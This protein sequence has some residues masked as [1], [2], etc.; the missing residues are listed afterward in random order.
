M[1]LGIPSPDVLVSLAASVAQGAALVAVIAGRVL[2][3]RR[4]S[5]SDD[6]P[7]AG[8]GG[9][10]LAAWGFGI[11]FAATAVGFVVYH[12]SVV[13]ARQRRLSTNLYRS[14]TEAGV[15]VGDTSLK[16]LGFSAQNAHPRG[17][18][19][20]DLAARLASGTPPPLFDVREPEE[21]EAGVI[22]GSVHHRY[23]DLLRDR[24]VLT[25]AA[26][27]PVLVCYS[28]N[29]SSELADTFAEQGIEC[30]FL[31]GG[32]EKWLAEGRPLVGGV[33]RSSLRALPEFPNRD[34]LLDTPE[35]QELAE[36]GDL[37]LVD[38]RYP[39]DLR[40]HALPGVHNITLRRLTTPEVETALRGLPEGPV[41]AVCYDKRG[42]FYGQILGLRMHRMGRDFRG[43]YTVPHEYWRPVAARAHVAAWQEAQRARSLLDLV[44][45]PLAAALT[46][47][48]DW[49]PA[50]SLVGAIALLV[51]ALRLVMLPLT[52]K[53]DVDQ[54]VRED[55][56]PRL[57]ALRARLA[58]EPARRTRAL[59]A[60]QRDAGLTPLRN[61]LGT[62]AIV[63]LFLVMF[64]VVDA[65]AAARPDGFAW[66]ADLR[67]PDPWLAVVVGGLS[68]AVLAVKMRFR[69]P[70]IGVLVGAAFCALLVWICLQCSAAVSI[71]LIIN[72]A[73]VLLLEGA[74]RWWWRRRHPPR[75]AV[76]AAVE[77]PAN[78]LLPLRDAAALGAAGGKARRLG[79]LVQLGLPVPDGFVLLDDAAGADEV[80]AAFDR[81][82]CDEVAVRSSGVDEDGAEHSFAGVFDTELHV[83]RAQLLAAVERVRGSAMS[84]RATAYA[85]QQTAA[86]P[87]LVQAMVPAER[88]G[89]LFT[90][91]PTCTGL[92][93]VEMIDGVGEDLVS[94]RRTPK[95]LRFGRL[96]GRCLDGA[97][98]MDLGPLLA[99]GA[100]LERHFGGPQDVEWAWVGGEYR[101]LQA[102]DITV[103]ATG[104]DSPAAR[105][106]G[107][108]RR[109]MD[110]WLDDRR[111]PDAALLEQDELAE[112]LPRPTAYSAELM[113]ALWAVD[114]SVDRA[115]RALGVPYEVREDSPS[116]TVTAFGRTFV[117][118]AERERRRGAGLPAR[119][120]FR[121]TLRLERL[122]RSAR[123][124]LGRFEQAAVRRA[125]IDAGRLPLAELL[126]MLSETRARFVAES[127]ARAE[128]I[129]ILADAAVRQA[130]TRLGRAGLDAAEHLGAPVEHTVVHRA[131]QRL[132]D[133]DC[134]VE[135]AVAGFLAEFA[136]RAPHDFELSAPRYG[137]Q[138]E[139]MARYVERLRRVK[140]DAGAPVDVP[141]D[142]PADAGGGSAGTSD[143]ERVRLPRTAALCVERAQRWQELKEAAK[144]AC[145]REVSLLRSLL[146]ELGERTGLQEAVF[147]LRSDELA[148][149][150]DPAAVADLLREAQ[151]RAAARREWAALE[152]PPVIT[153]AELEVVGSPLAAAAPSAERDGALAGAR[154]AGSGD[155]VGTVRCMAEGDPH[156]ALRPGEIL[157]TRCTDPEWSPLFAV[158]GGIVTEIG[159]WLSHAAILARECGLPAIVGAV[160]A[161]QRLRTG[162]VVR[163]G[164]DGGIEVLQ[165]RRAAPR[166]AV[167]EKVWLRWAGGAR[168]GARLLNASRAGLRVR[169][170]KGA[171]PLGAEVV[172][173]WGAADGLR[174][175]VASNGVCD[176]AGL[177]I[178]P[179]AALERQLDRSRRLAEARRRGG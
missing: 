148:R 175:Q 130:R 153:A 136:H 120:A 62:L 60:A 134:S 144:H 79:E 10:R 156:D 173:D 151:Q 81:L 85:G 95:T 18:D 29:R 74:V 20:Q 168:V 4:E 5:A 13:D 34:T 158:A 39:E 56:A 117:D 44:R 53:A 48:R 140:E 155:V 157:V 77:L 15:A 93:C 41:V 61:F 146:L 121:L 142:V 55:L 12:S 127:Y 105:L 141:A 150:D 172:V 86:I 80:L 92:A 147:D 123:G 162:D 159:G 37:V 104:A 90:E 96:S 114:G 75:P 138:P 83:G 163:L 111:E 28:G 21:T 11:A 40:A 89:V 167:D 8:K 43:R 103:R 25:A 50:A 160:G 179:C 78:G 161:S 84:A 6:D 101:L 19:S 119:T 107:E 42:S 54:R 98:P 166:V 137:E 109:L 169:V 82:G 3:G 171:P 32:Y 52:W 76:R 36:A 16:T 59:L 33:E 69:R 58:D 164:I 125:A 9:A 110:R 99:L 73:L 176:E 143:A 14:S 23:P 87:V 65:E 88:A 112:L 63:V 70:W 38:V 177:A 122:E 46:W 49:L 129:N 64:G 165:E 108:R 131:W 94:G 118:V 128:Q 71:Y 45:E 126:S 22:A 1:M 31:I 66:M 174:G 51:L 57:A 68:A 115:G 2:L 116:Y 47:L 139:R 133:R 124:W 113:E 170:P 178:E 154:V 152:L 24:S 91:D 145:L 132:G 106:E 27:T 149:L 7:E 102:R 100:R 30:R 67:Q 35:V 97:P 72:L 26:G 17:F 135:D